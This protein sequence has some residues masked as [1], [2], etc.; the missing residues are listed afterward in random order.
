M[1]FVQVSDMDLALIWTV[2]HLFQYTSELF[3]QCSGCSINCP[4]PYYVVMSVFGESKTIKSLKFYSI[5]FYLWLNGNKWVTYS[6][7]K[8]QEVCGVRE[9]HVEK[10]ELLSTFSAITDTFHLSLSFILFLLAK[11][12]K[13]NTTERPW[14]LGK[15]KHTTWKK[16]FSVCFSRLYFCHSFIQ[17][18]DS[19]L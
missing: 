3:V 5:L 18:I 13:F 2:I 15:C 11:N 16:W 12:V 17:N 10:H 14:Q 8:W 1:L 6:Y 9:L 7:T 19:L 4:V